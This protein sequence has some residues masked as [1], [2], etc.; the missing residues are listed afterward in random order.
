MHRHTE[1]LQTLGPNRHR[2]GLLHSH[3]TAPH[4]S[5]QLNWTTYYVQIHDC[6]YMRPS[7]AN[8]ELRPPNKEVCEGHDACKQADQAVTPDAVR[9]ICH[10]DWQP[11]G[12]PTATAWVERGHNFILLYP[13]VV[14]WV[15]AC[16]AWMT[17]VLVPRCRMFCLP[18]ESF[19]LC[20][21]KQLTDWSYILHVLLSEAT[22]L[23]GSDYA[24]GDA[25]CS[26]LPHCR[27]EPAAR[28]T[29]NACTMTLQWC[30]CWR[31]GCW[32]YRCLSC[33]QQACSV[34]I[35]ST[36]MELTANQ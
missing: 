22:L 4:T 7:H 19:L 31:Y 1:P 17:H 5:S 30:S 8:K 2:C 27:K 25:S 18:R 20:C 6:M 10:S 16:W 11:S 23:P 34:W 9:S 15:P 12:C 24:A 35:P 32:Q 14:C 3:Q 26:H 28:N 36:H 29:P 33:P 13:I 21:I